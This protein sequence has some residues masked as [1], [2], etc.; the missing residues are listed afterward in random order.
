VIINTSAG[1]SV[2]LVPLTNANNSII[3]SAHLIL[4]SRFLSHSGHEQKMLARARERG[5]ILR[6]L[7]STRFFHEF[8]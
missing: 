1:A 5:R 3:F 8:Y 4:F 7:D 2:S 6:K